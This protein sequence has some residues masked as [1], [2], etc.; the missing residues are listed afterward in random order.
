MVLYSVVG[1]KG[2]QP[3][4]PHM[5][6]R[7]AI[8]GARHRRA[9]AAQQ[10]QGKAGTSS[11]PVQPKADR[12]RSCPSSQ[13]SKEISAC[14]KGGRSEVVVCGRKASS[15]PLIHLHPS[16]PVLSRPVLSSTVP[17]AV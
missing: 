10:G 14:C 17:K 7:Q 8:V 5:E 4:K 11:H 16:V 13:K 15:H 9:R 2:A 3:Q 1:L 6:G 12:I